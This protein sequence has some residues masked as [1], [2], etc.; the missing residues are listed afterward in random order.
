V[1]QGIILRLL[2]ALGWP[3][4]DTHVV[5]PEFAP[6]ARRVDFA[7]C[8]P[9]DK[10]VA[11]IEV[12][13]I[14][15]SAGAERQLFEY[16]FNVGVPFAILTDGQEWNFFLSAEQGDYSER[17]VYKLDILEREVTEI[18]VRLERYLS[19]AQISSGA[20]IAAAREDDRNVSRTRQLVSMMP[21]AWSKLVAEEDELL[22]ELM[23]DKV[24]SLSGSKPAIDNVDK[25][26]EKTF[27]SGTGRRLLFV[28]PVPLNRVASFRTCS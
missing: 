17:R 6:G 9:S 15:Q 7:L 16:A 14:G 10:P 11:F 1:S 23:A 3:T 22:L 28:A 18:V 25:F 27:L 21:E 4:Y 26:C 24:E 2:Q 12:K 19:Y 20:A 8:H 5:C 13:D